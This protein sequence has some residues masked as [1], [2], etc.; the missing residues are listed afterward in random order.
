ML[1]HQRVAYFQY[2]FETTVVEQQPFLDS[3]PVQRCETENFNDPLTLHPTPGGK[4]YLLNWQI[5]CLLISQVSI[6][7][8]G[9]YAAKITDGTS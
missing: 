8:I 4:T 7:G 3:N 2:P 5:N 1:V 9:I 6:D